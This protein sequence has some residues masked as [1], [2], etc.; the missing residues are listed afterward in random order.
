MSIDSLPGPFFQP[1][2]HPLNDQPKPLKDRRHDRLQD[3]MHEFLDDD[4]CESLAAAI[5]ENLRADYAY[6]SA[7]CR[8][9]K[10]TLELL[11]TGSV[12]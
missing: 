8:A 4:D 9:I 2:P 3:V 12:Q 1:L 10:R 11:Q 7:K 6:Y 5:L